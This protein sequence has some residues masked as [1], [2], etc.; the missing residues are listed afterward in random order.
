MTYIFSFS[1]NISSTY[2]LHFRTHLGLRNTSIS[3]TQLELSM[4]FVSNRKPLWH[5]LKQSFYSASD[6]YTLTQRERHRLHINQSVI[7]PS[8]TIRRVVF[9]E[10]HAECASDRVP[11]SARLWLDYPIYAR[12]ESEQIKPNN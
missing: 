6:K 11:E 3:F 2:W 4:C 5:E 10:R 8:D 9:G 12:N 7:S 1:R